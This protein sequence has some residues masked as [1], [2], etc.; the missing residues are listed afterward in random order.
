MPQCCLLSRSA[1]PSGVTPVLCLPHPEPWP[2]TLLSHTCGYA[3]G[4]APVQTPCR[5]GWNGGQ[6]GLD[7]RGSQ[8]WHWAGTEGEGMSQSGTSPVPQI[9]LPK[10]PSHRPRPGREQGL[11]VDA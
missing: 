7:P 2:Q 8:G 3:A 5:G 9:H 6:V 4:P 11:K 1:G 10:E